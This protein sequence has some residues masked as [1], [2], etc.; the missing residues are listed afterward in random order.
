M[1]KIKIVEGNIADG[2]EEKVNAE[3]E[4]ICD[5]EDIYEDDVEV[6]CT[7]FESGKGI[8]VI[9]YDTYGRDNDDESEDF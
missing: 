3:I 5:T 6:E 4:K 9:K 2:L 1:Y 8:I 7:F